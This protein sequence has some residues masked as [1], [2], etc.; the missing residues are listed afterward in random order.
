M[1]SFLLTWNPKEWSWDSNDYDSIV[2]ATADGEVVADDRWS[3]GNTRHLIHPGDRGYLLRQGSDRGIIG[4]AT[5]VSRP[6]DDDHY[7]Y[8]GRT[9]LYAYIDWDRLVS[10]DDRVRIRELQT[11]LPDHDWEPRASGTSIDEDTAAGLEAICKELWG[12]WTYRSPEELTDAEGEEGGATRVW[13]NRY[14]RNPRFRAACIARW[15]C[16]CAACGLQFSDRYGPLGNGFIHVHHL[17]PVSSSRS[18]RRIDP[19]RD[20]R[21]LCPNCHAMVHKQ[22]PPLTVSELRKRLR[23]PRGKLK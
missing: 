10:T 12:E 18:R 15:G 19:Q 9:A 22:T 1:A 14:E 4:S 21:P 13:V 16:M 6:F 7:K 2:E 23:G 8:P 5:F 3:V 17:Q 20:L 11:R